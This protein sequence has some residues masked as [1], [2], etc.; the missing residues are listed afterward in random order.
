MKGG[1]GAIEIKYEGGGPIKGRY[2]GGVVW[3]PT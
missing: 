3:G 1:G 2:E